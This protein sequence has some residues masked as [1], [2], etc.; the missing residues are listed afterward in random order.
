M[1]KLTRITREFV[2][3][4]MK[5]SGCKGRMPRQNGYDRLM[6]SGLL[7]LLFYAAMFIAPIWFGV[8]VVRCLRRIDISLQQI[9]QTLQKR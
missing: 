9:S 7:G 2:D 3:I 6:L 8:Y 1:K 5:E 4:L